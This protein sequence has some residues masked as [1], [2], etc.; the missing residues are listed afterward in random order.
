MKQSKRISSLELLR[1]ISMIW[2]VAYHWQIHAD[3]DQIIFS[4]LNMNQVFSFVMGSWGT[5]G[6]DIFFIISAYF[7]INSKSVKWVKVYNLII[8]V[9]IYGMGVLV[10]AF[11]LKIIPFSFVD[12]LKS[13]L[14]VFVY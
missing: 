11:I 1:I 3:N 14:G 13:L 8:K 4:R 6:V 7:L 2:I 10:L 12:L 9:S 5:L